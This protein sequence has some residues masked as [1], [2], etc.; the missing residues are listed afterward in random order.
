MRNVKMLWALLSGLMVC[1]LVLSLMLILRSAPSNEIHEENELNITEPLGNDSNLEQTKQEEVTQQKD[2]IIAQVGSQPI[3]MLD[4]K[5]S[6]EEQYGAIKLKQLIDYRVIELEAEET[7]IQVSNAE[8]QRELKKMQ[9]GYSSEQQYFEYMKN[10]LGVSQQQM[11][12]E[13]YYKLLSIKIAIQSI[14]ITDDEVVAY[15][16]SNPEQFKPRLEYK[17][18]T[19]TVSTLKQAMQVIGKVKAG[20]EFSTVAKEVSLDDTTA[21]NGG[22]LGWI[23]ENDPF[24]PKIL[25][26]A[27]YTLQQG[28]MS[29]PIPLSEKYTIILLQNR[30][31][32]PQT[33]MKFIQEDVRKSLALLQAESLFELIKQ[34]REKWNA[35]ILIEKFK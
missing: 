6:L 13:I 22:D 15:I 32:L 18:K 9:E 25:L 26:Q 35:K 23:E 28:E 27:A 19:I 11:T 33:D 34:L 29:A 31:T 2:Q 20:K 5:N 12:E 17:L 3:Y 30:R 7:G 24:Y 1:V 21:A 16:E 14:S 10:E 8:L 4:L